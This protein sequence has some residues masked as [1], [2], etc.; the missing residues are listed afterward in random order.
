MY[1]KYIKR[2]TDIIVALLV[3]LGFCWLYLIVGAL[4]RLNL[5]SPI[6]F[7]QQRP[8]K[9][10]K[11]FTIYKFRSMI[12]PKNLS[13]EEEL[14]RQGKE[15]RSRF[16]GKRINKFGRLLRS[17]SLDEI[18]EF[19]NVLKGNMSLVGPRPLLVDYLTL[20]SPEQ[21]R[22]H[23]TK[24]GIT[25][26]AQVNGR[27]HIS[28]EEKFKLDVEYIDNYSFFMDIKILLLTIK[29]VVFREG[30]SPEGEVTTDDFRGKN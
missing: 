7:K 29:K 22:R 18:P 8:G 6:I 25:G 11:I 10:G 17:S 2:L 14:I 19:W 13:I 12:I 3:L 24:P 9:N 20:Y 21:A 4:V 23:E 1:K 27:E 26:W 5:G 16:D 15:R 30:V 28:W